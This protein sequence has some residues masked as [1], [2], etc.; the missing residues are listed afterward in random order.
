MLV[1]LVLLI[2]LNWRWYWLG[3]V[4]T[5]IVPEF[6]LF[7]DV[8]MDE[9]ERRILGRNQVSHEILIPEML[10]VFIHLFLMVVLTVLT[11]NLA[12]IQW[13]K[14]FQICMICLALKWKSVSQAVI[15]SSPSLSWIGSGGW[16]YWDFKEAI[17]SFCGV[18]LASGEILW[19]DGQSS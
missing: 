2:W 8:P 19:C 7:F 3:Y 5:G 10:F 14:E 18:Q 13:G 6:I 9:M 15:Q 16:Q 4:Q 1:I 12:L 17:E 11:E